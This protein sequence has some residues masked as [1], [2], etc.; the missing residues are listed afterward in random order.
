MSRTLE[1]LRREMDG[2]NLELLR[3]VSRR[4][5]LVRNIFALKAGQG[6][7]AHAPDREREMLERVVGQNSGPYSDQVIRHLFGEIFA[8]SLTLTERPTDG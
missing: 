6:L 1:E 3:L 2:V 7:P 8:A 4:G 5:M